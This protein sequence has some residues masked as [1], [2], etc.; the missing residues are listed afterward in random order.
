[1][2]LYFI[3][4][5]FNS[6]K[7]ASKTIIKKKFSTNQMISNDNPGFLGIIGPKI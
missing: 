3:F 4:F 1:M 5:G 6:K 7:D 2:K